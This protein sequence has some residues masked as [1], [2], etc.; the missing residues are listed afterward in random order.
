MIFIIRHAA[1]S[2]S[3]QSKIELDSATSFHSAQNDEVTA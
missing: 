2:R 1:R 3:I